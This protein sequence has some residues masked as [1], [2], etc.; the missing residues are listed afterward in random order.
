[1]TVNEISDQLMEWSTDLDDDALGALTLNG[2]FGYIFLHGQ[3]ADETLKFKKHRLE[4]FEAALDEA[5]WIDDED[6]RQMEGE[7][8]DQAIFDYFINNIDDQMFMEN[9]YHWLADEMGVEYDT[10]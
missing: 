3:E 7:L 8:S 1:M 4:A 2:S 6:V 9:F 5:I 10:W